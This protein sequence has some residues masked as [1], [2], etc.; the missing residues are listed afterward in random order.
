MRRLEGGEGQGDLGLLLLQSPTLLFYFPLSGFPP[1]PTEWPQAS[2]DTFFLVLALQLALV[3]V[4]HMFEVEELPV[5]LR[6]FDLW[7]FLPEK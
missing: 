5:K 3:P 6:L 2:P 1:P 4:V 7:I